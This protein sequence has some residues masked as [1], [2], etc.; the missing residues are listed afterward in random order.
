MCKSHSFCPGFFVESPKNEARGIAV[1]FGRIK[2]G[3]N[4]KCGL[5]LGYTVEVIA[6]Q[7]FIAILLLI[8]L[9]C[10]SLGDKS[11]SLQN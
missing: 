7:Y 9:N 2:G 10:V 11:C 1:L 4:Q 3:Q 5:F 8:G 6:F